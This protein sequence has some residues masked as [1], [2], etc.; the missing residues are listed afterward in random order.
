MKNIY[1][2]IL[3]VMLS[4]PSGVMAKDV[5]VLLPITGAITP[6]ERNEL[7][8]LAVIALTKQFDLKHGE[9]V[10][11]KVKQVFQE[12]SKRQNCD[13]TSCYRKIAAHYQAEKIIALRLTQTAADHFL[14]V[15]NIYD[16]T[17]GDITASQKREC[18]QCT[19]DKIKI[20]VSDIVKP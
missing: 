17:T 19:F 3:L 12:E 7:T 1:C 11:E 2:L 16:V 20:L 9:A 4:I 8:Q 15:L 14:L 5:A 10:D 6:Q 18:A 13:E